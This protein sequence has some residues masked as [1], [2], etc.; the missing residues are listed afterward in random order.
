ME[1]DSSG[2]EQKNNLRSGLLKPKRPTSSKENSDEEI[3]EEGFVKD[4]LKPSINNGSEL[5]ASSDSWADNDDADI[6]WSS[7]FGRRSTFKKKRKLNKA[8][9]GSKVMEIIFFGYEFILGAIVIFSSLIY[10]SV[11]SCLYI[12]T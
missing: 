8:S 10:Q 6:K 7:T 2:E 12:V 9:F 11:P 5:A 1:L 3:D 4:N